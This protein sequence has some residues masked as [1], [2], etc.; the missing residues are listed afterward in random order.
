MTLLIG[1]SSCQSNQAKLTDLAKADILSSLPYPDST[2]I[3]DVAPCDSAFGMY[4]FTEDE[5]IEILTSM[6]KVSQVILK[7]S[8][9]LL[10]MDA[11][12]N[13]LINLTE[14]HMESAA[15]LRSVLMNS[16]EKGEFTGWKMRV[17]YDTVDKDHHHYKCARWLF[18]NKEGNRVIK[19]FDIP[20]I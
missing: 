10:D 16:Q 9:D 3:I 14:R 17:I 4:Y 19:A 8:D 7:S 5:I 1:I 2:A 18:F 15:A 12:N 13:Y 6:E 11:S 20:L